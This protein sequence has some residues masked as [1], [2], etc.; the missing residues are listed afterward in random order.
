MLV[1]H[2]AEERAVRERRRPR[3]QLHVEGVQLR[4]QGIR[5]R[6]LEPGRR[7]REVTRRRDARD[8]RLARRVVAK[9][10]RWGIVPDNSAGES[11]AGC[12]C[13]VRW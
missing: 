7:R 5:L 8:V 10:A 4:G 1:I 13:G 11:L 9:L 2:A 12:R 3:V 6:R